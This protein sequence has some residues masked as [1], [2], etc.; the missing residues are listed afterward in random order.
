ME[1]SHYYQRLW[2]RFKVKGD[3]SDC[4]NN[5]RI[6]LVGHGGGDRL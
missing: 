1:L 3:Y 6:L 5:G 4:K 2:K